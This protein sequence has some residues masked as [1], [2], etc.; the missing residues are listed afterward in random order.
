MKDELLAIRN[1][2]LSKPVLAALV[3]THVFAGRNVPPPG[4]SLR[5][6][7]PCI[8]FKVRGGLTDYEDALLEPSIQFKC[9]AET[10]LL[11]QEVYRA[12]FDALQTAHGAYLLHAQLEQAGQQLEEPETQWPFI[13]TFYKVFVRST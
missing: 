6:S 9:Y 10:E 5:D 11:A 4:Y 3:D 7:G 8:T 13:L 2:L 12:L 1:H